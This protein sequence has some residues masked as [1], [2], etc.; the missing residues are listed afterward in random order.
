MINSEVIF[1]SQALNQLYICVLIFYNTFGPLTIY[2]NFAIFHDIFTLS[3]KLPSRRVTHMEPITEQWL[4]RVSRV[5]CQK[6]TSFQNSIGA[7]CIQF[8]IEF[9]NHANIN[10]SSQKKIMVALT[11]TLVQRIRYNDFILFQAVFVLPLIHVEK[12]LLNMKLK[13]HLFCS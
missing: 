5:T 6:L 9:E 8:H 11:L 10:G 13:L 4:N 1:R 12:K 3:T 7:R 2:Q